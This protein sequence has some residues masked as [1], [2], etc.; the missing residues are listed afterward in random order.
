MTQC[1]YSWLLLFGD[2]FVDH[3]TK[4]SR[5]VVVVYTNILV[6]IMLFVYLAC[7]TLGE[8]TSFKKLC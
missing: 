3:S 2:L 1:L 7:F 8:K 6:V 4:A 5:P